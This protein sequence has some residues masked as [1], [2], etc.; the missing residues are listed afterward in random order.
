MKKDTLLVR[1]GRAPTGP[2]NPPVSRASTILFEDLAAFDATRADRFGAL[3]YGIHGTDTLFSL[4]HA[5]T[6]LEGCHRAIVVPSGLAAITAALTAVLK[7]GDHLLMVDTVYGPTRAFCDGLLARSGVETTYY[8]PLIGDGIAELFRDNTRAVFCES[9]GSLTFEV[10]DIPAIAKAAHA[11]SIPVLLDNTWASPLFF[12]ALTKGVDISIQA[13]T[14]Y[15]CGHSDV[16]M[17]TIATTEG[18]WRPIR[19]VVADLGFSTSPDDCYLVLRGMRTLGVRMRHQMRSALSV[20]RWLQTQPDVVRVLHP[21]LPD[22]PGHALWSR[23]FS[24]SSALFGVELASRSQPALTAF[25]DSLELFG[26]GSSWG[27]YESLALPARFTRTDRPFPL[28]GTLVRLHVGLEDPTDL[29]A[30]LAKALAAMRATEA[31]AI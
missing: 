18:W 25:M 14:K 26:I 11:R 5:I 8:D 31:R 29:I 4:E 21:G 7:T 16:M 12:D 17:G 10:Q 9:P 15:L 22:D 13:A 28:S 23:D 3:R 2:V 1:G 30:D 6:K 19:D 27:G 24:G 20:A